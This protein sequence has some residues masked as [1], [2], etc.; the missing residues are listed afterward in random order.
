MV[1]SSSQRDVSSSTDIIDGIN[2]FH[3]LE[4][5]QAGRSKQISIEFEYPLSPLDF[6]T[7]A[8]ANVTQN[9]QPVSGQELEFRY[10]IDGDVRTVTTSA[11]GSVNIAFNTGNSADD[12]IG[13]SEAG[14]HGVIAWIP[15]Q[16]IVG[17][18]TIT[19]DPN[20]STI[21]LVAPT[22]GVTVDRTRGSPPL[23]S[24]LLQ[25]S[26]QFPEIF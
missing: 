21:D 2:A 24:L 22:E 4:T 11:N 9:G 20:V 23:L 17:A 14:S 26:M 15:S 18:S 25:D 8:W 10:G 13:G 3:E 19:I 6:D 16:K 5:Y 1:L 12:S 7:S